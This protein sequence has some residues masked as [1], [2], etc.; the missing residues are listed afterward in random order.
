MFRP[1]TVVVVILDRQDRFVV[2]AAAGYGMPYAAHEAPTYTVYFRVCTFAV[3]PRP[4]RGDREHADARAIRGFCPHRVRAVA[5]SGERASC[6]K[7]NKTLPVL[8]CMRE[9]A[10]QLQLCSWG[11]GSDADSWR[12][13]RLRKQAMQLC[14]WGADSDAD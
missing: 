13:F 7:R 12:C 11:A 1:F 4:A 10:M 5:K 3:Q 9:Q 8:F 2:D 6:S 14:S